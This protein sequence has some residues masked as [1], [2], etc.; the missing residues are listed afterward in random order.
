MRHADSR[1]PEPFQSAAAVAQLF[2]QLLIAC[3]SAPQR[4][5]DPLKTIRALQSRLAADLK[6]WLSLSHPLMGTASG[7]GIDVQHEL[8]PSTEWL[9]LQGV[10]AAHWNTIARAAVEK[11]AQRLGDS[12]HAAPLADARTLYACWIDCAEEAYAE[13]ASSAAFCRALA[14][15]IRATAALRAGEKDLD[16]S[17]TL[18]D[19]EASP[20]QLKKAKSHGMSVRRKRS[21]T[22]KRKRKQRS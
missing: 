11:F 6:R 22:P 5:T 19:T 17:S 16:R 8:A 20:H 2:E 9:Q 3:T 15:L 7:L 10:F 14:E 4:S 12:P 18:S 1:A 21:A 13:T